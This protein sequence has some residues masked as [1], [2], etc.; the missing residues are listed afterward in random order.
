MSKPATAKAIP[1]S[2]SV[3]VESA[4]LATRSVQV[5][6][7]LQLGERDFLIAGEILLEQDRGAGFMNF[8]PRV[9]LVIR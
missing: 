6:D 5:G 1:A 4:F 2:G 3:W 7:E 8:A 9:M